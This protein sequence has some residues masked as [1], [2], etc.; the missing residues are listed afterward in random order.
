MINNTN[1]ATMT[2]ADD[3]WDGYEV[4]REVVDRTG[5]PVAYTTGK[6]EFLDAFLAVIRTRNMW[7]SPLPSTCI[8]TVTGI[9]TSSMD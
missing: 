6:K 3:L 1:L 5:I 8:C 2:S 4:L 9:P 7:E